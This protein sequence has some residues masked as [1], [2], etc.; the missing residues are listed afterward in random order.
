MPKGNAAAVDVQLVHVDAQGALAGDALG[1]KSLVDLKQIHIAHVQPG[2]AQRFLGGGDGSDAH[3][4]RRHAGG[5]GG[6]HPG[7]DGRTQPVRQPLLHEQDAGGGVVHAGGVA[8]RHLA[9]LLEGGLQ[10]S[11]LLQGGVPLGVFVGGDHRVSLPGADGD[12]DDLVQELPGVDSRRR[13]LL[14]LEGIGVHVLPAHA[15]RVRHVF[16]RDAHGGAHAQVGQRIPHGIPQLHMAVLFP[17]PY[18]E[19]HVGR[20]AHAVRAARHDAVRLPRHDLIKAHLDGGHGGGAVA[21]DGDAGHRVGQARFDGGHPGQVIFQVGALVIAAPDHILNELRVDPG[22]LHQP[23]HH[24][25]GQ[26]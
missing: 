3:Q 17:V 4:L 26:V 2:L 7:Q 22:A 23:L 11:Q 13:P 21:V 6:N 12:G 18:A 14:G 9:A 5:G 10:L 19:H 16:R 25:D 20:R 24:R 8:R 15:V 1:G